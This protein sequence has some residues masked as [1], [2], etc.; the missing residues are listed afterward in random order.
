MI[1]D[2]AVVLLQNCMDLQK[3]AEGSCSK[4][5]AAPCDP[6]QIMSIKVEG[7]SDAEEEEEDPVQLR[8]SG[9]KIE[10]EVSHVSV[11]LLGIF[12]KYPESPVVSQIPVSLCTKQLYCGEWS[13]LNPF[14]NIYFVLLHIACRVYFHFVLG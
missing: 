2:R 5:C 4:T 14:Q 10:H 9:I 1:D 11:S 7:V 13:F 8:C 3:D 12:H 6:N